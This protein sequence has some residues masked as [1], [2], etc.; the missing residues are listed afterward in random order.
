MRLIVYDVLGRRVATFV[1]QEQATGCAG[2]LLDAGGLASGH[3]F[4]C[5]VTESCM[6]TQ[7]PAIVR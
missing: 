2:I 3:Y 5:L 6:R 4:T 1:D 7:R